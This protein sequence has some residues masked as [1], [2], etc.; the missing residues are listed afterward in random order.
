V[1]RMI[2]ALDSLLLAD[3]TARLAEAFRRV[4]DYLAP[5]ADSLKAEGT[6]GGRTYTV[7]AFDVLDV[8]DNS[9]RRAAATRS[10]MDALA[11]GDLAGAARALL[12]QVADALGIADERSAALVLQRAAADWMLLADSRARTWW[13]TEI[14]TDRIGLSDTHAAARKL[15]LF[16]SLVLSDSTTASYNQAVIG[17]IVQRLVTDA[18]ALVDDVE[19]TRYMARKFQ[20]A[21]GLSDTAARRL[22]R[23]RFVL[24][25]LGLDDSVTRTLEHFLI[26]QVIVRAITDTLDVLD[27]LKIERQFRVAGADATSV[28]DRLA[29]A[30][31]LARVGSDL[32]GLADLVPTKYL[33]RRWGATDALVLDDRLT[34]AIDRVL[35]ESV[36]VTDALT[37]T[38]LQAVVTILTGIRDDVSRFLGTKASIRNPLARWESQANPYWRR[39]AVTDMQAAHF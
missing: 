34:R 19:P 33:E 13:S 27:L 23:T 5:L 38:W 39:I 7:Q 1:V 11:V 10:V 29:R 16:E 30:V 8:V 32:L 18:L 9:G 36:L 3:R 35:T 17:L 12:R 25:V 15:T 4:V 21:L 22:S 14:L 37:R 6:T 28:M 24:D 2:T 20:A 31:M 26:G